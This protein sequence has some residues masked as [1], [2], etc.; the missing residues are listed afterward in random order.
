MQ[1]KNV[2]KA[3]GTDPV[4]Y[5]MIRH[6]SKTILIDLLHTCIYNLFWST[7]NVPES[8]KEAEVIAIHKP[9]KHIKDP[10]EYHPISQTPH[11][12]KILYL[13]E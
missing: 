3:S 5:V 4:F 12:S 10:K 7:G 6:L 9:N 13:R 8:W 1:I 11:L 2:K